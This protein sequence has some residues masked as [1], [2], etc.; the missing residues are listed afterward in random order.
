MTRNVPPAPALS[1]YMQAAPRSGRAQAADATSHIEGTVTSTEPID[2]T[3]TPP[4]WRRVVPL[5]AAVL[6]VLSL[7]LALVPPLREQL[8]LSASHR[9][10]S[11]VEL[12]FTPDADGTVQ[13]CLA[14][15]G[16]VGVRFAMAAHG[17]AVGSRSWRISITDP[18]G[19]RTA[20]KVVSGTTRLPENTPVGVRR[21]VRWSGPYDLVVT[22]PGTTQRLVAHCGVTS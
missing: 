2:R 17:D 3:A 21:E 8:L 4:W 11:Y 22:L 16:L 6:L 5:S 12:A 7:G 14:A 19:D 1:G 18:R 9:E 10:A 15:K 20:R 13:P